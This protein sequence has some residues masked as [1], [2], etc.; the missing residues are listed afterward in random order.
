MQQNNSKMM[1]CH[2]PNII[3]VL[4]GRGS[5]RTLDAETLIKHVHQRVQQSMKDTLE[6]DT[7]TEGSEQ[8]LRNRIL[9]S[10]NMAVLCIDLVGSTQMVLNLPKE[11]ISKIFTIFAQEMAYIIRCQGGY[12]LK[13]MGDAVIGY[14]VSEKS[15]SVAANRSIYCAKSMI[16]VLKRGINPVLQENNLPELQ[17]RIGID[18]GENTVV[19]YGNDANA[20]VDLLG[21]SINVASKI[22]NLVETNQIAVGEDIYTKLHP[23]MQKSLTLRNP[24]FSWNYRSKKTGKTYPIYVH[25]TGLEN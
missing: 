23:I 1:L 13:F 3:D 2:T 24:E 21:P 22:Q 6:Y 18:Y 9:Q 19:L 14:F 15:P 25:R 17:I 12:V 10:M 11:Q 4:L 8:F 5:E 7:V 20:H 16:K